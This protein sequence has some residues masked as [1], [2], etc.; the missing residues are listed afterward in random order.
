MMDQI[1]E[2]TRMQLKSREN[3]ILSEDPNFYMKTIIEDREKY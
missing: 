2:L 1:D 3:L